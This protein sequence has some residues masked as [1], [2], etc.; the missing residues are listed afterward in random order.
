MSNTIDSSL[1]L[2]NYQ[3]KTR[4]TGT[5][6]LG[7]DDFLK[8]LMTQLQNQDPSNP[9]EDKDFIAQMAQFSTLEQ[10]TNMSKAFE[11][12]AD[13]QSQSNLIQYQQFVGKSV[14][15]H[16]IMEGAEGNTQVQEGE[17]IIQSIQYKDGA[18]IFTLEN[19]T[20]IGPESISQINDAAN[21]T[22]MMQASGLIGKKVT[23]KDTDSA[24]HEGVVTSVSFKNGKASF[25]MNDEAQ[26]TI[27]SSQIVQISA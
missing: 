6:T 22:Y 8:I 7:K 3:P 1:Y 17:G 24:E 26:S 16:K 13:H 27:T 4:Q 14:T 18:A 2:S 15:W 5:D 12:F 9:L 19:G 23:W 25:K 20:E 11:S 10:I 21:E